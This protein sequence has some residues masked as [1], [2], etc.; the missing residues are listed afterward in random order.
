MTHDYVV[1][2]GHTM[3]EKGELSAQTKARVQAAVKLAQKNYTLIV[4]GGPIHGQEAL[5]NKM[6]DYA[7]TLGYTEN[8]CQEPL[9]LDTAGQMVFLKALFFNE[10]KTDR[11][12][13]VTHYW[14]HIKTTFM[15]Y[16]FFPEINFVEITAIEPEID[17]FALRED[18]LKIRGFCSTFSDDQ[19]QN[20]DSIIECL[21]T[22]HPW[23]RGNYP[24]ASFSSQYFYN[25]LKKLR[26]EKR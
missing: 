23:Y 12:V 18:V 17:S 13:F 15:A 8:I 26:G 16:T 22:E 2:L 21:L 6:A 3:N 4:S 24:L 14:H 1:A 19:M 5:S 25:A 11:L 7:R 9:S 10:N 20:T